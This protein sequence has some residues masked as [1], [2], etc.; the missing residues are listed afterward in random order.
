MDR[1]KGKVAVIT[2]ANSG[3]GETTAELFAKEGAAVV[4]VARRQDKLKEVEERITKQGGKALTVPGDVT[5][6]A[7]CKNVFKQTVDTFGKVDILVNNAGIVD[8]HTP[9]IR[10]TDELWQNVVDVNQTGTFLFCREALQYMTK[11]KAGAII[12][13]SSIAGVYGNGGAAYSASKYAVI[14]LTKNIAIQ[15][16]GKGIRCNAVCPGPTPTALNAP[17]KLEH[18]DK[19]FSE[20]CFR[21]F[22]HGVGDSETIDQ[23]NAIL[24][25]ANDESR[26][27]TGQAL[28]IDRGM[29]L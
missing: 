25:F 20:I 4:L 5:S 18:F 28:V 14:G 12:N 27:I 15:Y 21:H 10:T 2:G 3:I 19:E 24:F 23:A 29:C 16:A 7:D 8:R 26:C 13:V 6:P 11:A 22:D 17:E 1:L 9:T